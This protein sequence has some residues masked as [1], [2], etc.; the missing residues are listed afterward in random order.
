[1]EI[2]W[3]ELLD[4]FKTIQSVFGIINDG[5]TSISVK[6]NSNEKLMIDIFLFQ[7]EY[8]STKK[9]LISSL[10]QN[11]SVFNIVVDKCFTNHLCCDLSNL[12]WWFSYMNSSFKPILKK[13]TVIPLSNL[14]LGLYHVLSFI[15]I[16]SSNIPCLEDC[17]VTG[18]CNISQ[19]NWNTIILQKLQSLPFMKTHITLLNLNNLSD[20]SLF[21]KSIHLFF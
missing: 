2:L 1:M 12:F 4:L 6:L 15:V 11:I 14:Y 13:L 8:I 5:L 18:V 17:F 7:N 3:K 16:C 20:A 10:E 19:W 9:S 21:K